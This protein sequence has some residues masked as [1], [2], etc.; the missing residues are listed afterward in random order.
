M[1]VCVC[2]CEFGVQNLLMSAGIMPNKCLLQTSGKLY[3]SRCR[4]SIFGIQLALALL[5]DIK[6][7]RRLKRV[8]KKSVHTLSPV[9]IGK[10]TRR[11]A[12][13]EIVG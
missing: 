9:D 13:K 8:K 1:C 4:K 5:A 3:G 10:I 6:N 7:S 2:V 11:V 12:T